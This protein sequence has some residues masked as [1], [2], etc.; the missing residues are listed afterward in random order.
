MLNSSQPTAANVESCQVGIWS[1]FK[2][3]ISLAPQREVVLLDFDFFFPC[4]TYIRLNKNVFM[5]KEIVQVSCFEMQRDLFAFKLL[6]RGCATW[7]VRLTD[8]LLAA[9][10][11]EVSVWLWLGCYPTAVPLFICPDVTQTPKLRRE[12]K[13]DKSADEVICMRQ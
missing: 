3:V 9:S 10:V 8:G 6:L 4:V 1:W 2:T 12:T 13:S 11:S 7:I 5:Y